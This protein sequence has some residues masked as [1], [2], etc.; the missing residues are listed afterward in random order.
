MDKYGQ[1]VL[2]ALALYTP[3]VLVSIWRSARDAD[4][5]MFHA[6]ARALTVVWAINVVMVIGALEIGEIALHPDHAVHGSSHSN[7]I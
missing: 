4:V 2:G 7:P 5:T 1:L 6:M 3:W